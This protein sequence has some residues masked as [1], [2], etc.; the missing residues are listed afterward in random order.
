MDQVPAVSG[1]QCD[2]GFV[3]QDDVRSH[4]EDGGNGCQFF[5]AAGQF[6]DMLIFQV[7]DSGHFEG[8]CNSSV[9]FFFRETIVPRG[10]CD[11]FVDG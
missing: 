3:H 8:F 7:A 2:G 1:I 9:D 5:L 6:V 4:G 11:I 10:K